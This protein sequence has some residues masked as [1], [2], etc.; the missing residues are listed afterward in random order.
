MSI[1]K[2]DPNDPI[3]VALLDVRNFANDRQLTA[4]QIKD[5]F[6]AGVRASQ[7]FGGGKFVPS[8]GWQSEGVA[9]ALSEAMAEGNSQ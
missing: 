9:E 5:C 3:D 4:D 2:F 1:L 7:V 6:L 8:T